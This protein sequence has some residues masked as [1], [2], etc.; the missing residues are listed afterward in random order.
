[1][2]GPDTAKELLFQA[3]RASRADQTEAVLSAHRLALTRF[4][5]NLIHQNVAEVNATLTIRAVVGGRQGVATT[6]HLSADGL[7]RAADLA[8]EAALRQ[9][10]DPSFTGLPGPSAPGAVPAFDEATAGYA[11]E[12]RAQAVGVVCR[13]AHAQGVTAS[14]AFRTGA[15]EIAVANSLGTFAYHPATLADFVVTVM[16]E[17]S[18]GRAQASSGNVADLDP[19]A[20]GDEA[21]GKAARGRNPRH[22][23]PGEYA[24]VVDAY[25]TEDLLNMLNVPGMSAQAVQEGRSWMNDRMGQAVMSPL[26]SIWDDGRDRAG[27][28]RPFDDEGVPKQRVDIV[29][30]GVVC[31]PVYDTPSAV[32]AGKTSTGHAVGFNNLLRKW[33]AQQVAS[34]LFMAPGEATVEAMIKSTA[35][36]L[37]VTRF[38]YTRLVHPRD[39]VVTGMTRD[40]LFMIENGEV[41]FPVKNL[42]FTQS[43]VKALSNLEMLGRETRLA[44]NEYGLATRAPALKMGAF[45]FTGSTA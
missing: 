21:L 10:E 12:A 24:V 43:Y 22:I 5:N 16:T 15:N 27:A 25:V 39:C 20:L 38:W 29:T 3:L 28:P 45:S 11:P 14:G 44:L 7:A 1:M 6:N 41:T 35:R 30:N 23:A 40:G 32:R 34:N 37:Y 36:G 26:V 4:A 18:A 8:R 17:D 13:K 42:R 9:P 19:E 31:Q 2:L 33:G